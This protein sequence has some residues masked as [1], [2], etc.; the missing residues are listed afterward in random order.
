MIKEFSSLHGHSHFS[1]FDGLSTPEENVKVAKEKGLRS[2]ALTD[3]GVCHG[4]ADFYLAGKKHG[5]RTIF[6]SEA[7]VIHDLKEW[8][9][10]REKIAVEKKAKGKST[11]DVEDD[12]V[13]T[14]S[15]V[16]RRK[17][18]LVL[19]SKNRMGLANLNQLTFRSHRDGFYSKPRMDK[20]MLR[21]H[22]EGLVASSACM[23]GVISKVCWDW[24]NKMA[25]WDD[26]VREA[27]EF[28][29]IFGRGNFYLELQLNE[30]EGQQFINDCMVRVHEETGIPLT[31]TTDF[32]YSK[33]EEWEARE[34]LHMLGWGQGKTIK[35]F[36]DGKIDTEIKQLYVKSAEEMW[37]SFERF[38]GTVHAKHAISA[39][40]N[41]LFIDSLVED[42]EPDTTQ[43]LPTLP[44][45]NPFKEMGE[46]AIVGLRKLGLAEDEKYKQR[47]LHELK[48]IKEKGISNY[49]LIVQSI[50]SEA[51][52]TMLVGAGR[53][54]A[55]GSLV[56]YALGITD[57]DPIE[58]DLMFERF[59]DP[60]RVELPDIDCDFQDADAAKD[61]LRRMFGEDNV[62]CLSTY[63]TFQ[64]KGL[65][66]DVSRVYDLDHTEVNKMNKKIESELR[67]LYKN[68]D[69]ST[70]VIKLEDVERVSPT[71]RA[72][73]EKHPEVGRHLKHLYNRNRHI[74]RHACG[75]VIGDNLPAETALWVQKDKNTGKNIVQTSFT[76]G[77]V[78][79]HISAMGFVKFDILS[80]ATLKVID[81]ALRL[82]AKR[83]GKDYDELKESIRPHNMDM[84]DEKVIKNVFWKG[85][86]T[87]IFQFT[88]KGIRKLA[89]RI[90]PDSFKD[91]SA[92]C[93]LYRPGP[94]G[95]GMD[96]LYGENKRKALAGDLTFEHPVLEQVLGSTYGCLVF[97]EQL[98]QICQLLGKME[99]K[100]VQRVRKV[101][102][103]KDKSKSAEFLQKENDE[104]KAK[105]VAGC[106]DNGLTE[107]KAEQWWKDLLYFGGYGFNKSHSD[108]YSVMT[109]QCAYL[110]TYHPLE[111]Y[112]AVLTCAQSGDLQ[113]YVDDIKRQ[114]YKVLPVDIN[115]SE[116]NHVIEGTGIRLAFTSV[117]GVGP[118]AI[119]K[120]V[121]NQPYDS[122]VDYLQKTGGNKTATLPLIKVG[123][124]HD[125]EENVAYL[126]K[127]FDV[128]SSNPKIR[129]KK[130]IEELQK[131]MVEFGNVPN[132]PVQ[133]IIEY[134]NELLG[135]NLRGSPFEL[136]GRDR[137]LAELEKLGLVMDYGDF[138]ESDVEMTVIPVILKDY[139]ERAQSRGGMMAFMKFIDREG[140]EFEAP[141]FAQIWGAVSRKVKKGNVYLLTANRKL[142][143]PQNL[144]VGKPG[145]KHSR[146]DVEGYLLNLDEVD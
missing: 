28:D 30:H 16:L 140:V 56:C 112:S 139:K 134:E 21:T 130:N 132:H 47:L 34:I 33:Q 24:F 136:L 95:S 97:Q 100:D 5:V 85:N 146:L 106:K 42:F 116:F 12:V 51:K 109:M 137:K 65:L 54:S 86:F 70:I 35:D 75:V 59:L 113:S 76:E 88:E 10:L 43:R 3:H 32:H 53:G 48:T 77:I 45:K 15:R 101:L 126:E 122:F 124:F 20:E 115:R 118:A 37:K 72:F 66:K 26:V 73:V 6:G 125:L 94:L 96:K 63:G 52:K 81:H 108:A 62:A 121:Q 107:E 60:H 79:K 17:G 105:F 127:V 80:I 133:K 98:M 119:K 23:G 93:S 13:K 84:D 68:Q 55:A 64:I 61:M 1:I 144:V 46:R 41:T 143:E 29:E 11:D 87:G 117:L 82:I 129:T 104:L 4:H 50:I 8:R 25:E 89:Q 27:R 131:I 83:D 69:K 92:I 74:G 128:W 135:F 142:E 31:V 19:L 120:I 40:E 14:D 110:A 2:I 44:Y 90:K 38:G 103:K 7:Y 58:H 145:W 91:V 57:L 99:F 78:N 114:G 22:S 49:F 9:E 123:A 111:F 39:F 67:V 138:V 71:F 141:A 102:L 36:P 18:H